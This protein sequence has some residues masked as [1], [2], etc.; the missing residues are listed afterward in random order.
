MT[1]PSPA[2]LPR[3][4]ESDVLDVRLDEHVLVVTLE[5]PTKANAFDIHMMRELA[6]LWAKV[7]S[8][9]EIRC[10]VL[11]GAG[12]A[13]S[14]GA[15]MSM[16]ASERMNVGDTAAE[17]LSFLPGP[18]VPMPVIAAVNGICAGGGLH[19]VAD[20]DIS[21]AGASARFVDPHV[22]VGQ[23][24]ALEPLE[25]LLRMRPDRV[26]RM[27]L[28]GRDEV[29]DAAA[30]R[31]SGLVSEVVPD[32]DLLPR[33]MEL[34]RI[35]SASSPEAV[36]ISRRVIR[37]YQTGLLGSHPDLGWELIQRHRAHPDAHEGP[38]A[39]IEKRAPRWSA[40]EGK[41]K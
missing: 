9:V 25:L 11:T 8:D 35:V 13:F 30:A 36:R 21:I 28:L 31:E 27:A 37:G 5:R 4:I 7:A 3:Y 38:A 39:F 15:D 26:I 32:A 14:A 10:V 19:F 23:V 20:A 40:D 24:T 17:E 22:S 34:A 2:E 18:T 6:A 41:K 1:D 16:L 29:L 33:A 12:R